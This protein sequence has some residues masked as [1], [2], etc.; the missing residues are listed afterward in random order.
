M[1]WMDASVHKKRCDH[2]RSATE[3]RVVFFDVPA[4][5]DA[6]LMKLPDRFRNV[7]NHGNLKHGNLRVG[8]SVYDTE[9]PGLVHLT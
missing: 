8:T 7:I 2:I 1:K 6:I 9:D 4:R 5:L 3:W